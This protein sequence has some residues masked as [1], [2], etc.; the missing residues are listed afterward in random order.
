MY[1][2]III[3]FKSIIIY[4]N[5]QVLNFTNFWIVSLVNC[6]T[7]ISENTVW[8]IIIQEENMLSI[9]WSKME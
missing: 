1:H 6:K 3:T 9:Y 4:Q 2:K 7:R 8:L 5:I